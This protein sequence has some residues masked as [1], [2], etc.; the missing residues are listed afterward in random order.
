MSSEGLY[1]P[2][3]KALI[4]MGNTSRRWQ[5]HFDMNKV[6]VPEGVKSVASRGPGPR[7][8]TAAFA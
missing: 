3:D 5:N 2:A 6:F 7:E 4:A 1:F 8:A